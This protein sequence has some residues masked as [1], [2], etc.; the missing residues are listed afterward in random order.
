[1]GLV[2]YWRPPICDSHLH[3]PPPSFILTILIF[4]LLFLLLFVF[5]LPPLFTFNSVFL[6]LLIPSLSLLEF[7]IIL[8]NTAQNII[9]DWW[10]CWI[11]WYRVSILLIHPY[12]HFP[13]PPPCSIPFSIN[14]SSLKHCCAGQVAC[15]IT[16]SRRQFPGT[17]RWLDPPTKKYAEQFIRNLIFFMS[18]YCRL[19]VNKYKSKNQCMSSCPVAWSSFNFV[20][21]WGASSQVMMLPMIGCWFEWSWQWLKDWFFSSIIGNDWKPGGLQAA[22]GD[23]QV[24]LGGAGLPAQQEH[25]PLRHRER[26]AGLQLQWGWVIWWQWRE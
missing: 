9:G 22:G 6:L 11:W 4:V 26:P 25:H 24:P 15:H 16:F 21:F 23:R 2:K 1:M 18:K 7:H 3:P 12:L 14:I 13:H 5:S 20:F 8:H 17:S 19:L 10:W